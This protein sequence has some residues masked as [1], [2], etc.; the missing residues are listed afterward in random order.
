MPAQAVLSAEIKSASRGMLDGVLIGGAVGIGIV[1]L[2]NYDNDDGCGG[3]CVADMAVG[4]ILW[5]V[6][7][8]AVRKSTVKV[9]R[10]N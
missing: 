10:Q 6:I 4:G 8:G 9:V 5:G 2:S 1:F 3:S 7:I